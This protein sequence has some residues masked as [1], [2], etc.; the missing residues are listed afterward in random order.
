MVQMELLFGSYADANVIGHSNPP[1]EPE[2]AQNSSLDTV[3]QA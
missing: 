1:H 2:A 3:A